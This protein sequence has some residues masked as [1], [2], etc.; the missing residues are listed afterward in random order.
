MEE[1]E[2]LDELVVVVVVED[3]V[4]VVEGDAFR[5][6]IL[7]LDALHQRVYLLMIQ[8]YLVSAS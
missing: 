7:Q 6:P 5:L 1:V 4:E 8:V 3:D 2:V